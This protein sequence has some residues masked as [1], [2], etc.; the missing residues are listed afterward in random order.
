MSEQELYYSNGGRGPMIARVLDRYDGKVLMERKGKNSKKWTMFVLSEKF[1]T[2][3]SCG[4]KKRA[5]A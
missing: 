2:S 5:R 1:L 3:Q 4:W